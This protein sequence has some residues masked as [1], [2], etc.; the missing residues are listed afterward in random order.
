MPSPHRQYTRTPLTADREEVMQLQRCGS[1][2]V[3]EW[4]FGVGQADQIDVNT[5]NQT[6][7]TRYAADSTG[8]ARKGNDH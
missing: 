2:R 8:G 4:G 1:G 5:N 7:R 6:I 3:S